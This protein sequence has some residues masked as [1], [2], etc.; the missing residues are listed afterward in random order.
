MITILDTSVCCLSVCL[1]VYLSQ[2]YLHIIP[3]LN[4]A[5]TP[6]D[7][8]CCNINQSYAF[9]PCCRIGCSQNKFTFPFINSTTPACLV[10]SLPRNHTAARIKITLSAVLRN[11]CTPQILFFLTF[12]S[13]HSTS[14]IHS[15]FDNNHPYNISI[16][17]NILHNG[18][19]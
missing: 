13:H 2:E 9:A 6:I 14:I 5:C 18:P 11:T 4:G 8:F 10:S 15:S 19:Y 7:M 12:S 1:S 16:N 3:S 17:N